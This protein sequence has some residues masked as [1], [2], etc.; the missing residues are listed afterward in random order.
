MKK[1]FFAFEISDFDDKENIGKK[2]LSVI[3]WRA[4]LSPRL[5]CTGTLRVTLISIFIIFIMI[6]IVI[7]IIIIVISVTVS[8]YH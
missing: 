1:L 3:L 7:M 2:D 6:V 5:H 4:G 8:L